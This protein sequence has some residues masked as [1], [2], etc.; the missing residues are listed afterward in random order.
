MPLELSEYAMDFAA[1]SVFRRPSTVLMS[2]LG[3]P[4]RT[5]MPMKDSASRI[6]LPGWVMPR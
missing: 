2:G 3:W 6:R 1:S 5:T 4:A